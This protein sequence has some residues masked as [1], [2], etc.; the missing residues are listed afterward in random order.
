MPQT[1]INC[2]NCRQPLMADIDQLFDVARD[3]SAKQRLLSGSFNYIQCPNCG[4]QGM[5]STPIVYHDPEKELLLTFVPPEMGLPRSEQE[6]LIGALI[7]QVINNLPQEKRKGYLLRPQET[8]TLQ[9][10]I[11][12]VLEGEGITREMIQAQQQRLSLIQR[13]MDAD[14]KSVAEIA[15]QEDAQIDGQFFALLR[16]LIEASLMGGDQASAQRLA[17]LQEQ[18]L[19]LTTFGKEMQAQAQEI[20]AAMADLQAAGRELSREKLLDLLVSAPTETRIQALVSLARPLMD[21]SFFSLLTESIEKAAGDEQARLVKLRE[22]LLELT[23]AIDEQMA[24]RARAA[25]DLVEAILKSENVGQ[26]MI[27]NLP[28]VDEL[29]LQELQRIQEEARRQG[30]LEKLSKLQQITDVLQKAT[31]APPEVAL[32]EQLLEAP[33]DETRRQLLNENQDS[34][35]PEFLSTLASI[36]SQIENGQDQELSERLKAVHRQAL[37]F[38]MERNL[39]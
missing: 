10:L 24:A 25:H 11:E 18:L 35:T 9:G 1:R 14:E 30:D 26:A 8:L 22:Q 31:S 15:A 27:E 7:N 5:V 3:P 28:A 13:L 33:D 4:F 2:P 6:R 38:S 34:I 32:I 12:R 36:A 17:E 16:R 19:P 21:Y 29:F 39:R 37:R 20:E 23:R